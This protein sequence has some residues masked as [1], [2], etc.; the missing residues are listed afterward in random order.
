[1]VAL[2]RLHRLGRFAHVLH[3]QGR[4]HEI[5]LRGPHAVPRLLD[6]PFQGLI[7]DVLDVS[8]LRDEPFHL[9]PGLA[10]DV[11]SV[12]PGLVSQGGPLLVQLALLLLVVVSKLLRLPQSELRVVASLFGDAPLLLR[13][14]EHVLE[15]HVLLLQE[16]PCPVDD[17]R[18]E[19][20][21]AADLEGVGLAGDADIEP[22][23]GT[24]PIHVEFHGGVLHPIPG[25]G[26]G[27]DLAVMGGG[28]G[29]AALLLEPFQDGLGKSSPLQG[30]RARAQLIE[31]HQGVLVR[32][33]DDGHQVGHMGAEGGQALLDGLLVADV[34]KDLI[35]DGD[36][37]PLLRRQEQAAHGHE[38]E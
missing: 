29:P 28:H 1:M 23:G 31:K 35:E 13:A 17:L 20:Q 37:A 12:L 6:G 2:P 11:P 14:A 30:V 4:V 15:G 34:R 7:V 36:L 32:L 18:G 8:Q 16:L 25:Q 9:P 21:T 26:E 27:L 19:A 24:E 3:R 10:H 33:L 22:V 5:V 38:G